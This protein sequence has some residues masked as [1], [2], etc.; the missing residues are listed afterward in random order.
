MSPATVALDRG[1]ISDTAMVLLV[2]LA[3]DALVSGLT[4]GRMRS[5]LLVGLWLGL[6]FQT[7]MIEAWLVLPALGL[8]YLVAAP[9]TVRRRFTGIGVTG[10]VTGAVSLSWMTVVSLVPVSY[11]H[12]DVYKRQDPTGTCRAIRRIQSRNTHRFWFL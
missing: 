5:L 10:V 3:A 4:S 2:V 12:L 11:T 1:N 6:A 7:K 9:G 8:A